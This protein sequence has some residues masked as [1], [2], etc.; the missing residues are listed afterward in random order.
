[1]SKK[2]LCWF[3]NNG[4]WSSLGLG[5]LPVF[6][7]LKIKRGQFWM[8]YLAKK[9]AHRINNLNRKMSKSGS[10]RRSKLRSIRKGFNV[11][12]EEKEGETYCSGRFHT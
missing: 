11:A 2:S 6:D 1:M 8:Q 12:S 9:D 10:R 7:L 4:N 3:K 5:L